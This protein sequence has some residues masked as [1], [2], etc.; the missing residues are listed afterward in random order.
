MSFNRSICPF[1]MS[2][3]LFYAD[4]ALPMSDSSWGLILKLSILLAYIRCYVVSYPSFGLWRHGLVVKSHS[5][6]LQ[7]T[8]V[9]FTMFSV[10]ATTAY[11][12]SHSGSSTPFWHPWVPAHVC[13]YAH[14]HIY[15][16]NNNIKFK[17]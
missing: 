7:R 6:F 14:M 11:N 5:S 13:R 10:V 17:K 1:G 9:W 15:I 16:L 3:K 12:S 8:L 2:Y 4:R